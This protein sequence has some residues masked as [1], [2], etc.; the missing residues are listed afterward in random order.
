MWTWWPFTE[1]LTQGQL[2]VLTQC[3]GTFVGI[4]FGVGMFVAAV[5]TWINPDL[6][7]GET[8]HVGLK[9][10]GAYFG[11]LILS[12]SLAVSVGMIAASLGVFLIASLVVCVGVLAVFGR[13]YKIHE[14]NLH[15][16]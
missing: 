8:E 9:R 10:T 2:D 5:V 6:L 13:L 14:D 1:L 7:E 12:T 3:W 4:V 15:A 11:A 16:K